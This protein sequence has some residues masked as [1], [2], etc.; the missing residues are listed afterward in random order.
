MKKDVKNVLLTNVLEESD[1]QTIFECKEATQRFE[2]VPDVGH[3]AWHIN[4]PDHII[5]KFN[6]E[7]EKI[8]GEPL[9]L[10]AYQFARYENK[11]GDDGKTYVPILFPHTD[12]VFGEPRFTFDYQIRSNTT[13]DITV[14][15]WEK[16]IGYQ[17]TDNSAIT[18]SG[19]HQI[20]WRPKKNFLDGEFIE[21]IFLHYR[22][23]SFEPLTLEH[24]NMVRKQ[25]KHNYNV[26]KMQ[27]GPNGN[28]TPEDLERQEKRYEP[29]E[30]L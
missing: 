19:T 5:Q 14:D 16:V 3:T 15:N 13:W 8:A 22:P 25:A 4:L 10:V 11:V 17:L 27:E 6:S 12:E 23:K 30:S 9:D 24:Y 2:F 21:M 28:G 1:I 20:H 7:A 29:K 18:F 26:W